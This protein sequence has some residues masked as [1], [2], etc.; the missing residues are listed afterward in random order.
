MLQVWD[1]FVSYSSALPSE[2]R[3]ASEVPVMAVLCLLRQHFRSEPSLCLTVKF[4]SQCGAASWSKWSW[5]VHLGQA[6]WSQKTGQPLPW[7]SNQPLCSASGARKC[8][9]SPGFPKYQWFSNQPRS[10]IFL[11]QNPELRYQIC[12]L[13]HS[14]P[15][16]DLHPCNLPFFWVPSHKHRSQPDCFYSFLLESMCIFLSALVVKESFC[17]LPVSF[18]WKIFHL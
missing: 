16:K 10:L 4:S 15:R 9:R 1:S 12:D 2:V 18:Q 7:F 14:V 17:Q 13:N 3:D 8:C 11:C 5:S 6:G